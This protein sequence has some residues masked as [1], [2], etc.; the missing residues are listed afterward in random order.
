[1]A[2]SWP[3]AQLPIAIPAMHVA[4]TPPLA[5]PPPALPVAAVYPVAAPPPAQPQAAPA[6]GAPGAS[7]AESAFGPSGAAP[8]TEAR[9]SAARALAARAAA[10]ARAAGL[11][12]AAAQLA[13][14][15]QPPVLNAF[16]QPLPPV[17]PFRPVQLPSNNALD[18][19]TSG[20]ESTLSDTEPLP[21]ERR[22]RRLAPPPP[23]P[24]AVT[25]FGAPPASVLCVVHLGLYRSPWAGSA[26]PPPPMP[27]GAA[28]RAPPP[29]VPEAGAVAVSLGSSWDLSHAP[30]EERAG[31]KARLDAAARALACRVP[32][33]QRLSERVELGA[34]GQAPM[35][36]HVL[37]AGGLACVA[38]LPEAYPLR[39]AFALL[40][41][42]M[43]GFSAT[44]GE[45]WRMERRD[46]PLGDAAVAA[47]VAA[48]AP[49]REPERMVH[50][51]LPPHGHDAPPPPPLAPLPA[52]RSGPTVAAAPAAADVRELMA[53][54]RH[55][56][57]KEAKALLKSEGLAAADGT[58]GIDTR[59]EYGN[60][61]LMVACQVRSTHGA[62]LQAAC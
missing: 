9:A 19:D 43:G 12:G 39:A 26:A 10:A 3:Q 29:P 37:N 38:L 42:A 34:P 13:E 15:L 28:R 7:L 48:A 59:D 4:A 24:A 57:Y 5:L 2:P 31:E 33:G 52:G 47:A 11:H 46:T 50:L 20:D 32:P 8:E 35:L 25:A 54:A 53:C 61:A 16:G 1:M 41:H 27:A 17:Q 23:P 51:G 55:G 56:R 18:G 62:A 45:A 30:R 60:T 49:K 44:L 14:R 21:P 40:E 58:Y 6:W 22:R 36:A